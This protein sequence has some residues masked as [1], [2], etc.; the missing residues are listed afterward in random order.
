MHSNN[1]ITVSHNFLWLHR[2]HEGAEVKLM[3]T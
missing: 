1:I 2:L 3:N